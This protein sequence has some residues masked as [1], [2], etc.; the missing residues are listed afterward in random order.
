MVDQKLSSPEKNGGQEGLLAPEV[1]SS[2]QDI[3]AW[4]RQLVQGALRV[5]VI[6]GFFAA[7]AGSYYEYVRHTPWAIPIYWAAYAFV[8][9]ITFW[10]RVPYI[11]QAVT[12]I[13]TFYGLAVLDFVTDGRGGGGRLFP[14][15]STASPRRIGPAPDRSASESIWNPISPCP[16]SS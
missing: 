2:R 14:Q 1:T 8:V 3:Q 13:V 10:R 4:R 11:V 9:L 15:G 12:L 16:V 7:A 5:S 6:V